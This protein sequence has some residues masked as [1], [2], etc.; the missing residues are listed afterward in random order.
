MYQVV[1]AFLA[2]PSGICP[3]PPETPDETTGVFI[4]MCRRWGLPGR[5]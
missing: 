3:L 5:A 2:S 1:D 4:R